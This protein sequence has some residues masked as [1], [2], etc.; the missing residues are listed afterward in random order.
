MVKRNRPGVVLLIMTITSFLTS[1]A[2][3]SINVALPAISSELRM[4]AL[5]VSWIATAFLLTSAILMI[6]M[7][8]FADIVGRKKIYISGL[9]I[10]IIASVLAVVAGNF[11]T[12]ILSRVIMGIG[13]AMVFSTSTAI[14][15]SV[16]PTGER[17]KALGISTAA[18][19]VGLSAGPFV[20]GFLTHAF[21]WRSIFSVNIILGLLIIPL[22]LV[23]VH[24]EWTD[25]RGEKM[26]IAGSLIY[27][28]ALSCL[29]FGFSRLPDVSGYLLSGIALLG[30]IVFMIW[31]KRITNP[32]LNIKLFSTNRVF[33]FSNLA[34][35]INY[36]ATFSV[37]FFLSLY[38]QVVK[39]FTPQHAGAI[40]LCQPLVQAIFSPLMGRL[41]DKINP[42]VLS[43]I[44]MGL[45]VIGLFMLSFLDHQTSIV[46]ITGALVLLGFGFAFFASPNTNAIMG[47][48]EKRYLSVA[49][50]TVGTMRVIG[51]MMSMAVAMLLFS[52][53]IGHVEVSSETA[54]KF[55]LAMRVGYWLFSIICLLGIFASLARVKGNKIKGFEL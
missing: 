52:L 41:S 15:L 53:F 26:D 23:F 2:G 21:G 4:D 8:R 55:L 42:A 45:T 3:S 13:A 43:S 1:Y 49:S 37:A 19:Y 16:Y 54:D 31:E 12:L 36:S 48:V 9:C 30:L 25:A 18:V 5:L 46:Y 20:G 35:L 11:Q 40:I 17:G 14:L 33:A 6:P 47:S 34:A 7:G 24:G 50:A 44:G 39:G 29:L 10:Y 27:A 38:L 22:F 28:V 32:I 51:Q